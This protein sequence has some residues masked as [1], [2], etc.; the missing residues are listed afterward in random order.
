MT[1]L[2]KSN[3]L[4]WNKEEAIYSMSKS[5]IVAQSL[6]VKLNQARESY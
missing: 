3:S 2:E 1:L 4:A 5:R 6:N